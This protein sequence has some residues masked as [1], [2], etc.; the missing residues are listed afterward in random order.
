MKSKIVIYNNFT[1]SAAERRGAVADLVSGLELVAAGPSL[2]S[3]VLVVAGDTIFPPDFSVE[4]F[5][6]ALTALQRDDDRCCLVTHTDCGEEELSSRGILE[7]GPNGRVQRFLEKP[8]PGE[9]TSRLQAPCCYLLS[10]AALPA[11]AQYLA[12][13]GSAAL[14]A[15]DSP[16]LAIQHLA[17]L[18][19]VHS[20]R[21]SARFDLGSLL[22]YTQA[23]RAFSG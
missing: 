18:L 4:S 22:S 6:D 15:R 14:Q 3:P 9:T 7:L 1:A 10:P 20:Y 13:P 19:P 21:V 5:C 12:G 11:L 2:L 23:D 8:G 16:G 17:A